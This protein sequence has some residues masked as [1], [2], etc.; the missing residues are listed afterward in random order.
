[1][2][3]QEKLMELN[4][5]DGPNIPQR[6][7]AVYCGIS[8]SAVCRIIKGEKCIDDERAQEVERGLREMALQIYQIA[9][10]Q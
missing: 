4:A 5:S 8:Q 2:T 9:Y 1:M 10:S 7:L 3:L 6:T